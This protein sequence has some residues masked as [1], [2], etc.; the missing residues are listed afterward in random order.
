MESAIISEATKNGLFAL[1]FVALFIWTMRENSK[2]ETK[3]ELRES[4]YQKFVDKLQTDISCTTTDSHRVITE[5][6]NDI[7]NISVKLHDVSEKV[8]DVD[9]KVSD[10]SNKVTRLHESIDPEDYR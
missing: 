3:S 5:I 1:L 8:I 2:R 7:D 9:R 4:A 6:A 10:I